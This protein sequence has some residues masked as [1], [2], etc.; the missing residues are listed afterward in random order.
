MPQL[1]FVIFHYEILMYLIVLSLVSLVIFLEVGLK[2]IFS[3]VFSAKINVLAL[4]NN[5][6]DNCID[7]TFKLFLGVMDYDKF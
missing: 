2:K 6:L 3:S 5:S 4:L 1:D 7:Y